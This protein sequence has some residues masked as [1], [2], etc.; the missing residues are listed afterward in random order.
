MNDKQENRY[1]MFLATEKVCD[2]NLMVWSGVPATVAAVGKFKQ[3]VNRLRD[4][5][6]KQELI[7]T[8]VR[9]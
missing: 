1:S 9:K 7:I 3:H 2:L 4:L 6:E 8:G 5:L